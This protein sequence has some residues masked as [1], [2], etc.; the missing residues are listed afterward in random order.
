MT[1]A[2]IATQPNGNVRE[3]RE[4]RMTRYPVHEDYAR[5]RIR[6]PLH[7]LVLPFVQ[8]MTRYLFTTE[9]IPPGIEHRRLLINGPEHRKVSLEIYSPVGI[10]H[11]APSLLFLHG[12]AFVLPATGFHKKLI[13]DYAL[14]CPCTVVF[15][16]YTLAPRFP[17]PHGLNDCF[18]AYTW[19]RE[20]ALDLGIDSD[21]IGI[22]GD[23]AGG[24]LAA[25]L[26]LLLRDRSL[27]MPLF[28]LLI[29]PVLDSSMSS[30][31]MR[32]Y[33]D[34]PI[35]NTKL[36][37]KM[38]RL[39]VAGDLETPERFYASPLAAKSFESLPDTYVE[40]S[41]FDCLRDEAIAFGRELQC[42]GVDVVVNQT[43]GTV[44]GCEL[45]YTSAHTQAII[46][47]RIA[48]MR[49]RFNGG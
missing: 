44:H 19:M 47:K 28:Q 41:E 20:H 29:Y 9:P 17:Y 48:Y 11:D 38:W 7:P 4:E 5:L 6:V 16:D 25:A 37:A 30:E 39:Y 26:T 21:R 43:E 8:R 1:V 46:R 15:V 3:K 34:T 2:R 18:S 10:E 24:A 13:C 27:P 31:S 22:C 32:R 33:V 12:G 36:N 49:Q 40:V 35:W 23:S 42:A 14:G 45:N